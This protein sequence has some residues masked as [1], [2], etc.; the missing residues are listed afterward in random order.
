MLAA[1]NAL[2][3]RNRDC[4]AAAHDAMLHSVAVDGPLRAQGWSN[5]A[6]D[7]AREDGTLT[8]ETAL[9]SANAAPAIFQRTVAWMMGRYFP[10]PSS[11]DAIANSLSCRSV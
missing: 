1:L 6:V 9:Y 8:E 5:V 10:T 11:S 3:A 7:S 4:S 2:R